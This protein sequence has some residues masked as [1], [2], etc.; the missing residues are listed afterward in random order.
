[1]NHPTVTSFLTICFC[2]RCPRGHKFGSV[3]IQLGELLGDGVIRGPVPTVGGLAGH[4]AISHTDKV[5]GAWHPQR[6]RGGTTGVGHAPGSRYEEVGRRVEVEPRGVFRG[7]G[8]VRG[9]PVGVYEEVVVAEDDVVGDEHVA[10]VV[11]SPFHVV[12][13]AADRPLTGLPDI[14]DVKAKLFYEAAGWH[15]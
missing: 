11:S 7:D 2:R 13:V 14:M 8:G 12:H 5:Q 9:S 10:R 1:M 4:D 15:L 6:G 3:H